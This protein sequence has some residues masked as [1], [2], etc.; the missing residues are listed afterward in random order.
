MQ[1]CLYFAFEQS[2]IFYLAFPYYKHIP[3]QIMERL[4]ISVITL[5]VSL[6]TRT[7]YLRSF[8]GWDERLDGGHGFEDILLAWRIEHASKKPGIVLAAPEIRTHRLRCHHGGK[9]IT[10]GPDDNRILAEWIRDNELDK[11]AVRVYPRLKS[12]KI[13][14]FPWER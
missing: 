10:K 12:A 11:P 7:E 1:E 3:S 14:A 2:V 9:R 6:S 8:G 4:L 13:R 5:G